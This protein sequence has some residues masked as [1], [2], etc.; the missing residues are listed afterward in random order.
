MNKKSLLTL[1]GLLAINGSMLA[2]SF[3][4]S[5]HNITVAQAMAEL[6]QKTGYAFLYESSDLNTTRRVNVNAKNLNEAVSQI[7]KGQDVDYDIQGHNIVIS[8]K[9]QNRHKVSQGSTKRTEGNRVVRGTITDQNGDPVIGATIQLKGNSSVGTVSDLDGHF[10]LDVPAGAELVVSYIGYTTQTIKTNGQRDLR[11]NMKE[12]NKNLSEVVVVGYGTQKKANLTGA[13]ASVSVNDMEGRPITNS[14]TLLQGTASGV[15]ALQKS[16][17]PGAD[18]AVV[19]IRGVGTLNNSAPLVIIDGFP[20]SVDDVD[21]S[22]IASISVLK[23]AAS[24]SIYGNRAANGVIL[25]TTKRGAAGTPTVTYSGYY[26]VQQATRLPHV[27]D[28]YQ[29]TTLYNE[30]CQNMG[31][32]NK[33]SDDVIAKYKAGN[34]PMYPS[35]NYFDIYYKDANMSNHRINVSGGSDNFQYAVMMGYLDQDGILVETNYR[36]ADFRANLDSW[37]LNRTLRFTTRLSGN[38]G[39]Q[40]QPTDL[41]STIWYSTLAPIFPMKTTDGQWAAVNGERNYY[42]EAKEGSTTWNKTDN[43]NGQIEGEYKFLNGFSLQLTYGYNVEHGD[44]NAFNAN[45]T[46]GNADG[47]TK[48]LASN[49]TVTNSTNT[50]SL[51]TSLLR[52]DHKFGKQTVGAMLGYSEEYFEWKWNSGYRSGFVNNSQRELNLGD[53]SSQTNNS[54]HYDLGLRSYFGRLNYNY[55]NKYIF[56]ANMRRDGSSRFAEGHKWGSFPSFSAGWVMSEEKFMKPTRSW[57]DMLKV[58]ASWGKLGNQNINS[59]Y[60]GS[61]VLSTGTNYSFGGSLASGVAV[62]SLINKNTTWETTTQTNFGLDLNFSNG[63]YATLDYFIKKT[64]DILMQ[65]P[66]PLTMGNLSAPYVNVGKVENKGIEATVGYQKRFSN[67]LMLKTYANLSHIKNKV[68]DLNG[69]SPI[70]NAPTALVEGYAIN[71]FY[72]YKQDGIYQISDFT[73]QNNSDP[74]I[75]YKDRQYQLKDGVARVS[76]FTPQPGDIKYKDLDSD[77]IVDM[78]HDR[79][80]IGK[81]FPDLTYAWSCNLEWKNFDFNMFWQGVA[82]IDGYTYYEIATCFSGFANMGDWWL[83]R[84]TPEN[85][86]NKYPR[87]TTDGVRNNIHSTFYME[88]ASYLRLKNIELGY[89]FDKKL[90]PFLGNCKVRV[91]GNI[92]NAL[93]F[94]SYKG[95]D[96]EQET[97]QTR[98]EAYPQVRIYTLG[99]SVK[100]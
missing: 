3:T 76:N 53:A 43:F 68:T 59:Y 34:D 93:T 1:V 75:P 27:L 36:K 56:E 94:T 14:S 49:L 57:L 88:D 9:Q 22:E 54:G 77:G 99:L 85:P 84:W 61:D 7:V 90:L 5:H 65:T 83:D 87:L 4:I 25:I 66:I 98:A 38:I 50:Q 62:K 42:G 8:K 28:S 70:I 71:S 13:V 21:A 24:S 35:N 97:S 20:G 32:S 86:G 60:V 78:D 67:G 64:D 96:P 92:Q 2:Q 95:F 37:F 31:M 52:Y 89:T 73:W 46:L 55:D 26:G 72:G 41:W 23:D 63:I 6:K 48:Q 69:A 45:V 79:T 91:Y 12:D 47:T 40:K 39:K 11:V 10:T 16:G 81:Q 33:Y 44:K 17:Q 30:A 18:G 80:V 19:N 58:R 51:L 100:F 74:N 15:Y 82:G 29:Y